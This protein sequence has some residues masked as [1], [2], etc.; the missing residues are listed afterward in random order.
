MIKVL[1]ADDQVQV[2]SALRL[3]LEQQPQVI[4]VGEVENGDALL[5]SLHS[6]C[7]DLVLLDWELSQAKH[8]HRNASA[9]L[10][11]QI[12]ACCPRMAIVALST[13]PEARH[14]ALQAGVDAFISKGDP[15]ERLLAAVR[16][17]NARYEQCATIA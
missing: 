16:D 11:A 7:V 2:R 3:L 4:V 12:R 5:H 13:L 1:L 17:A 9:G 6:N 10:V 14:A 8:S 15:P